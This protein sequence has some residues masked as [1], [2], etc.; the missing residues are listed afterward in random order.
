VITRRKR[1]ASALPFLPGSAPRNLTSPLVPIRE[2]RKGGSTG[3]PVL[4]LL[5]AC[6]RVPVSSFFHL[7]I[8]QEFLV[9]ATAGLDARK[10]M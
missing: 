1:L 6:V 5:S 7:G 10:A 4:R 2:T 9:V 8:N 3:P